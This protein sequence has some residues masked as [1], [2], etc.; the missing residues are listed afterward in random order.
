MLPYAE[1]H[2]KLAGR[3]FPNAESMAREVGSFFLKHDPWQHPMSTGVARTIPFRFGNEDWATYVHLEHRFDFGAKGYAA[4]QH[5]HK[6]VFL[7]EDRYEQDHPNI[8]D[9]L[10]MR[11]FQRRL[12]WSWLM[13]GGSANYG[14]RWWTIHPYRQTGQRLIPS[15]KYPEVMHGQLVGLD[16]VRFIRDYFS[17]RGLELSDF[18]PSQ[19]LVTDAAGGTGGRAPRLMRRGQAEFLV[20]HPHAT[21]DDRHARVQ[22]EKAA[23][24]H[25]D[26]RQAQGT[27]AVEWYRAADGVA[28]NGAP[29]EGGKETEFTSCWPGYDVVLRLV[30]AG[31]NAP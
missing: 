26:L 11:Y 8:H 25:I 12:F 22:P 13:A 23:Q 16:C 9:P 17:T 27:F 14:G 4:H 6:P 30:R 28:Q 10:D 5:F 31:T 2:Q 24:F 19:D 29:V 15:P 18:E 7:G 1:M 3:E 20:Y 21:S